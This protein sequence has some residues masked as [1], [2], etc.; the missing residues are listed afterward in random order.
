[1]I[2]I[3]TCLHN[4]YVSSCSP[5]IC[6]Y[7]RPRVTRTYA[8]TQA[9]THKN[10]NAPHARSR[11]HASSP[12]QIPP[13]TYACMH[14]CAH[15]HTRAHTHKTVHSYTHYTD[16]HVAPCLGHP[17]STLHTH[18]HA[19]THAQ[20]HTH[21]LHTHLAPF[22]APPPAPSTHELLHLDLQR[23]PCCHLHWHARPT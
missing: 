7:P 22:L 9:N 17:S 3:C 23:R 8:C 20:I 1:M 5:H 4:Y 15:T 10:T 2:G 12:I 6:T 16:T 13:H 19:C 11:L 14:A 18:M 21:T